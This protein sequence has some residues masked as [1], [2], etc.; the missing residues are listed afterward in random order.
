MK[1]DFVI[2]FSED[3]LCLKANNVDSG[4]MPRYVSFHQGIHSPGSSLFAKVL[5]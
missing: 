5:I 2:S 1:V 3:R 4:E